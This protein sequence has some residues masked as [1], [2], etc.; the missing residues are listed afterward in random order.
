MIGC[1][2]MPIPFLLKL[3]KN[4]L[5][6]SNDFSEEQEIKR[7]NSTMVRQQKVEFSSLPYFAFSLLYRFKHR[8]NIIQLGDDQQFFH[9]FR[10]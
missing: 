6:A 3:I 7:D 2:T 10:W 4:P 8:K 1:K 5:P 9:M